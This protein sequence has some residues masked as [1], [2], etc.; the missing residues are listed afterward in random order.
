MKHYVIKDLSTNEYLKRGYLGLCWTKD[1]YQ[2]HVFNIKMSAELMIG[3]ITSNEV[4]NGYESGDY[5]I[6][7]IEIKEI[8]E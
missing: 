1:L 8:E 6:V 4:S 7:E 5:K 3:R 2:A